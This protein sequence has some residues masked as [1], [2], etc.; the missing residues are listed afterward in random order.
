MATKPKTVI[1][2]IV[3]AINFP[4]QIADFIVYA[5]SVYS[6][7]MGNQLFQGALPQ[8]TTLN[9]DIMALDTAETAAK[10]RAIGA[11][12][13]R[14]VM[15]EVVRLDLRGLRNFV[16]NL[17]DVSPAKAE[18]IIS[19]SGMSVKRA[20]THGKQKNSAV[21]G[22]E[23]GTVLL[24]GEG[25]GPHE[26]RM[27]TDRINWIPLPASRTSKT[28]VAGLTS[29]TKYYFQNRQMLTKGEKSEWS[30]AVS[31]LVE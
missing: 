17:A 11:V 10:A 12:D 29:S 22:N 15:L 2:H 28:S 20:T 16:Q 1:K 30:E 19:S 31:I 14:N 27:S 18:E 13:T 24:T 6:D 25:T 7:M 3:A 23:P 21:N 26:W 8:L 4:K 9:M 5:K